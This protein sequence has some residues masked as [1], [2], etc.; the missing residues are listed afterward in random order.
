VG[1]F[2]ASRSRHVEVF[3]SI[4]VTQ[5]QRRSLLE[6]MLPPRLHLPQSGQAKRSSAM[7]PPAIFGRS[8]K[9][10]L[11]GRLPVH[12]H[13]MNLCFGRWPPLR[14][15]TYSTKLLCLYRHVRRNVLRQVDEARAT[16]TVSP[17]LHRAQ[18][19]E[20]L[21]PCLT[22]VDALRSPPRRGRLQVRKRIGEQSTS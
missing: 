15:Y 13:S 21:R 22:A 6:T 2:L 8:L 10:Y 20:Q 5:A 3:T 1:D 18:P 4:R 11:L 7:R 12:C 19:P 16:A 17:C 9:R 14:P